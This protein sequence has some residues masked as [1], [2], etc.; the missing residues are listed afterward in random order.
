ME[1]RRS[2]MNNEIT[3]TNGQ[4]MTPASNQVSLLEMR[5]DEKRFPRIGAFPREQAV[6]EMSKIVSQ[7]FLYKGQ[8]ADPTNIQFISCSLVD[9]LQA[10][11]DKLGTRNISFAE[12]SR[13]V[14]RAVLQDDM[15][16]ISVASLYKV[17]IEYVKGEGHNLNRQVIAMQEREEKEKMKQSI[18]APMLQAYVGEFIKK[19]RIK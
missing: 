12:I 6:F 7:A 8:A 5:M 14:K 3:T 11:L 19:H 4:L 18:V 9:E 16:G 2:M 1:K 13:I 10:D 15:Y 17:I